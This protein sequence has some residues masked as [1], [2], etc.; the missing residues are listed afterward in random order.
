MFLASSHCCPGRLRSAASSS[1]EKNKIWRFCHSPVD[2]RTHSRAYPRLSALTPVPVCVHSR[3]YPCLSALTPA[4]SRPLPLTPV[5][6]DARIS[7][8]EWQKPIRLLIANLIAVIRYARAI[9]WSCF[10]LLWIS[11]CSERNFWQ[12][13]AYVAPMWTPKHDSNC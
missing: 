10:W 13:P 6:A 5:H 2:F 8:G 12:A 9:I 11:C 7:I 4:H 3:A 1:Q